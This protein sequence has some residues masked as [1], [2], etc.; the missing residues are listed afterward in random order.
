MLI[1]E[2]SFPTSGYAGHSPGGTTRDRKVRTTE[3]LEA[4][5]K[6]TM[7]VSPTRNIWIH[8][9]LEDVAR[10]LWEAR[11]GSRARCGIPLS[12]WIQCLQDLLP[13][14]P[15]RSSCIDC[16]LRLW[17]CVAF[18]LQPLANQVITAAFGDDCQ[19]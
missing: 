10:N 9:S 7:K 3:E 18:V 17:G 8:E 14:C 11:L 15:V 2:A 5:I 6:E 4:A 12:L 16:S 13:L 19:T 1:R